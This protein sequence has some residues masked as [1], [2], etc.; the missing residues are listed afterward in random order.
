MDNGLSTILSCNERHLLGDTEWDQEYWVIPWGGTFSFILSVTRSMNKCMKCLLDS[1]T[2]AFI[3]CMNESHNLCLQRTQG[4]V[5]APAKEQAIKIKNVW[6]E[7]NRGWRGYRKSI[8]GEDLIKAL[9]RRAEGRVVQAEGA[10]LAGT[11]QRTL[12]KRS[13]LNLEE[14]EDGQETGEKVG[15]DW[16]GLISH[17]LSFYPAETGEQMKDLIKSMTSVQ[18]VSY[19]NR[20]NQP[21]FIPFLYLSKCPNWFCFLLFIVQTELASISDRFDFEMFLLSWKKDFSS[22]LEFLASIFLPRLPAWDLSPC[23]MRKVNLLQNIIT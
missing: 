12:L 13:S 7:P 8:L 1:R 6:N 2:H 19:S 4:F 23:E 15:Q 11:A 5:R 22:W 10:A 20:I 3:F 16:E 9:G 18:L 21:Y 14:L 17:A